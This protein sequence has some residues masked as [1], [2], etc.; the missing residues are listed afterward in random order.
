MTRAMRRQCRA[1]LREIFCLDGYR[2]GQ[3]RAIETLLS[4]R[5]LL[6]I[7]PTG[8][9]KSLCWQ[10]PAVEHEGLT[11]V[12]SP[13]IA[14]MRDQVRHLQEKGIPAVS[15]DSLMP[16]AEREEALRTLYSG[17]V[18]IVFLAPER[19]ASPSIRALCI[20][21]MPWL[22]VIDEAHCVVEW[23]REFRPAYAE[24]G[25]FVRSL[26]QRPVLCAM[27][28]TAD[29]RM[30]RA[31]TDSLGLCRPKRV[32]L[33]IVRDNLIYEVRTTLDAAQE[34]QRIAAGRDG[35]VVVYCRTRAR[36]EQLAAMLQRA[37]IS[38]AH[39]HAG[40][41]R[42]ARSACQERFASGSLRVLTATTA[43]GMGVD[44][45]D[46][47]CVVHDEPPASVTDY[48]QQS[49]RAGR[50]GQAASCILLMEPDALIRRS[51]RMQYKLKKLR[52]K[53]LQRLGELRR[54]WLP[55]R[56]LLQ[57]TMTKKCVSAA[58]AKALG[59]KA[60]P[61]GRCSACR[62]GALVKRVPPLLH[63]SETQMSAW[64]LRWQRQAI[65]ARSNCRPQQ[66]ITDAL[67]ERAARLCAVPAEAGAV[68][69]EFSRLVSHFRRLHM[70]QEDGNRTS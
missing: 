10:L 8:A 7:L 62:K 56:R 36:T 12:V 27:T 3:Q 54:E 55:F 2:P 51:M 22:V 32:T 40:M 41:E 59:S 19:L 17:E 23:G 34:I 70:H 30:Q 45:P 66:V 33:P 65:A 4:G 44:L 50:D 35:K 42:D 58:A 63:M 39:Y 29:K 5:D 47:R 37:G 53:P 48:I 18:R 60:K 28:A 38:A 26:K 25:D 14:L 15:L 61:C 57:V 16:A 49:G 31:L 6:C 24:I 64:F 1:A 52:W 20:Q 46:I 11:V 67:L 69:E 9:G 13:L 68:P 43:F 21:R